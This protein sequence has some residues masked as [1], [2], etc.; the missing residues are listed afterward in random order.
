[1]KKWHMY[2]IIVVIILLVGF[3]FGIKAAG[4]LVGLFGAGA[5]IKKKVKVEKENAEEDRILNKDMQ[6]RADK[7]QEEMNYLNN[8]IEDADNTDEEINKKQK[9]I[10][11]KFRSFF[12]MFLIFALLL[13]PMVVFAEEA[14][15]PTIEDAKEIPDNYPALKDRYFELFEAY[16]ELYKY[17]QDVFTQKETYK[18]LAHDYKIKSETMKLD[19]DKMIENDKQDEEIKER[20][21]D[22]ID[23]LLKANSGGFGLYGGVNYKL[24]DPT[25]SGIEL[26]LTYDF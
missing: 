5:G 9:K 25:Q 7:Y 14:D 19:L 20:L 22:Y 4:G 23:E 3:I 24:L 17:N 2:L 6:K 11:N 16:I 1:V 8:R 10:S 26:G 12:N 15:F 13:T 21:F 18:Q